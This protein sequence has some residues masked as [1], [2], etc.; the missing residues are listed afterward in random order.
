M[1]TLESSKVGD[2]FKGYIVFGNIVG[3]GGWSVVDLILG[4]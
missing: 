2:F 4:R 1:R 3:K